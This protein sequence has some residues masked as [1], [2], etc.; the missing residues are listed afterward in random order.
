[1]NKKN[2]QI[3]D[4]G[5]YSPLPFGLFIFSDASICST[6]AFSPLGNSDHV[7]VSVSIDF[8]SNS[9]GNPLFHS[10]FYNY[11]V[12]WDDHCNHLR[13]IPC[14]D[15]FT[16]GACAAWCLVLVNFGIGF[17]FWN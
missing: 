17:R 9:K 14:E 2:A 3:H 6:I 7:V 10:I 11:C 12:G 1:M 16:H 15:N 4:C 8:Q 5:S 13:D